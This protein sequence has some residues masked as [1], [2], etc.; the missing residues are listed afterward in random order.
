MGAAWVPAAAAARADAARQAGRPL[1]YILPARTSAVYMGPSPY[2][3]LSVG[4]GYDIR[5]GDAGQCGGILW[6]IFDGVTPTQ[7]PPYK[8]GTRRRFGA[9][10]TP[11]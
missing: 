8:G 2:I 5:C 9:T 3:R 7:A 1:W 10:S 4:I 11:L 6:G